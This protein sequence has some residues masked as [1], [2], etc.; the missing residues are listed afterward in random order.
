MGL[1]PAA[2]NF[3]FGQFGHA[4]EVAWVVSIGTTPA[5]E[6]AESS[7]DPARP[8]RFSSARVQPI[9]SGRTGDFGV[10]EAMGKNRN[11]IFSQ[12]LDR[13]VYTT[14]FLG[15]IV[16]LVAL[17]VLTNGFVLPVVTD[18]LAWLGL[19]ALVFSIASLS[20]GSFLALRRTTHQTLDRMSS[21]NRR[22]NA[23]L[24]ASGRLSNASHEAE[25]AATLVRCA[26]ELSEATAAFAFARGDDD[27][28]PTLIESLGDDSDDL[29][30]KLTPAIDEMLNLVMTQGKP[31]LRGPEAGTSWGSTAAA[32]IPLA[33]DDLPIGAL[34]VIRT[35]AEGP[36]ETTRIDALS[37]LA[38]LAS[39]SIRNSDLRDSQR[40]FFSHVTE[41]LVNALD[42][43]LQHQNGH[44]SRVAQYANR[45]GR[46][47]Q[48]DEKRLQRLHFS[49]LL[50]DIGMLRIDRALLLNAAACEKH[51]TIG[52]RMLERIRLWQDLAPI[53]MH[54]HEHFDGRGYP[55]CLAGDEIP[56]E[57]RI[58]SVC[59]AFDVM[60]SSSSYKVALDLPDAIQELNDCKGTQF[61]PQIVD[62]FVDLVDRGVIEAMS[63]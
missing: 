57:A 22:L 60:V 41:L 58:I 28:P 25:S 33:G 31:A 44:G 9:A 20:L 50:H 2:R 49:A 35:D 59:E 1:D 29:L 15:A 21:D 42:S 7:G 39:V 63:S 23:L 6:R 61:D 12:K 46:Q 45:V 36:F 26:L 14:Y 47:L 16:P 18:R 34:V 54:H 43:H 37:T 32:A 27:K 8:P 48:L 4:G 5:A 52:A 11:S 55:Q 17:A 19:V 38:A 30:Q 10:R 3:D 51:P 62:T 24:E 13:I 40:N 53:V 56:L